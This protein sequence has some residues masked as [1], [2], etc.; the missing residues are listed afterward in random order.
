MN[1][2]KREMRANR[3]SLIIWCIGVLFIVGS[4]MSKYAALSNGVTR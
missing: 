4:G 1:I 2:F 3:K